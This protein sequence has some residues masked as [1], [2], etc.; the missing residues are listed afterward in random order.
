MQYHFDLYAQILVH[1]ETE[2]ANKTKNLFV[3]HFIKLLTEKGHTYEFKQI[4]MS[5]NAYDK[6]KILKEEV[7][8]A[9]DIDHE[10]FN[11][12]LNKQCNNQASREDKILIERYMLKKDWKIEE[13]TS[14]FL[15][16]YYGKTHVLNNLRCLLDKSLVSL[17]MTNSKG[18][19]VSDFDGTNKLEQI[20]M[21]EEVI[22]KMG[23]DKVGDDKK[24]D[25]ETFEVNY[26]KVISESQLFVNSNKSQPMFNYD[27]VKI[28][29]VS[30]IKQF[31][32]FMNSLFSEW[33]IVVQLNK[34][35]SSR[36]I[37]S[38]KITTYNFQYSLNYTNNINK[39]I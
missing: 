13:I 38:K 18:D 15:E 35:V 6:N 24:L 14:E 28:G 30:T 29:K 21:I 36:K 17:Y 37:N 20:K 16:K 1:N 26:K 7:L 27:K 9:D 22:K 2:N 10:E 4:R 3:A 34:K 23:F 33:G 31:M 11:D 32:G 25:R 8:K 12:L 39:Y 19:E 5:K